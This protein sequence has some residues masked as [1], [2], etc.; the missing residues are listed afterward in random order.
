MALDHA[1]TDTDYSKSKKGTLIKA[2]SC[3]EVSNKYLE[4]NLYKRSVFMYRFLKRACKM[5][6]KL[7]WTQ[8]HN[9]HMT[10]FVIKA[11]R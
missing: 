5:L 11:N 6:H 7:P 2:S 10:N 3:Y 4:K 1:S 9:E 8:P